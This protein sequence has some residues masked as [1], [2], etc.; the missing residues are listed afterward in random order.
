MDDNVLW[1][2]TDF[3]HD[4]NQLINDSK[5]KPFESVIFTS[6]ESVPDN[7]DWIFMADFFKKLNCNN[8]SFIAITF[9][10]LENQPPLFCNV[11][12]L[13]LKDNINSFHLLEHLSKYHNEMKHLTEFNIIEDEIYGKD[14][15]NSEPRRRITESLD[16]IYT[17]K[18]IVLEYEEHGKDKLLNL[19]P[20]EG[21]CELNFML[22]RNIV[23]EHQAIEG[24]LCFLTI[25]R[26][27]KTCRYGSLPR[28]IALIIAK[29][30]FYDLEAW[31]DA[32]RERKNYKQFIL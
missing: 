1:I 27:R 21:S 10:H 24:V 26:F 19:T 18:R 15:K 6:V 30:A 22:A 11:K 13:T 5:I 23:A 16:R 29:T 20:S 17:L 28:E 31:V 8:L 12:K 7:D 3:Q 14:I 2:N 9:N 4:W 32:N 25:N